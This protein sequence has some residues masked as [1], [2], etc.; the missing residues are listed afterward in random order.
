[1]SKTL[2]GGCQC[3]AIRFSVSNLGGSS[4]CHCRMCQKAFGGLFAPLVSA[5]DGKWTRGTPNWFVSSNVAQRA[6]C[7]NCGTPLAYKTKFGLE[8]SIGA[9]DEPDKVAPTKQVNVHDKL[10]CYDKLSSL[11][12][13]QIPSD[14][15]LEFLN[16]VQSFQHPDQETKVWTP[17]GQNHEQ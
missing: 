13:K 14:E 5:H 8:L 11:P 10:S 4:V 7:K 12:K 3:G 2:Y 1:M 16:S 9:F 17:K 15:W 6:F